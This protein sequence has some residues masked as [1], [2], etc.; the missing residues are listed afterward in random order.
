MLPQCLANLSESLLV[1]NL[2]N[3][4]FVGSIPQLCMKGSELRMIDFNQNQFQG[5]LPRSLAKCDMVEIGRA[6]V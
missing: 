1:L 4:F 2:R 5:Q 6:H 3:N